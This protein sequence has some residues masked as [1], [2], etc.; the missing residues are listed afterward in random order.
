MKSNTSALSVL[1]LSGFILLF[2]SCISPKDTATSRSMQN[3][4][5]RYNIVYN[6]NILLDES[7]RNIENGYIDNYSQLLPLYKEPSEASAASEITNLDSLIRKADNI[8]N[9]KVNS[10]YLDEAY[11]LI[12]KS[13]YLQA[14]FF[15]AAEYFSYIY[16]TYPLEKEHRQEALVW[17]ARALMQ[18]ENIAEASNTL[19]TALKYIENSKNHIPDVY[20][21][22]AQLLISTNK[23]AE[24][25]TILQKAIGAN[26]SKQSKLR[27]TYILAQLQEE[28][29]QY[30]E[31]YS[32]FS[33]VVKSNASFEMAFNANLNRIRIEEEQSGK[34]VDR[35]TR[36]QSL[37]KDDKNKDF[38]DQIYFQIGNIYA[39]RN[40]MPEAIASYTTS[41][42]KTTFNQNQK[43]L[44]YLSIADM[45]FD[46][47]D[48]LNAKAYYDSTLTTLSPKYPGYEII[49]KKGNNLELLADRYRTISREDT[50]QLL[51]RLPE[52]QRD[53]RIGELVRQQ[54]QNVIDQSNQQSSV[55]NLIAG[56]DNPTSAASSEGKFYF[57]NTTALSQGLIDFKRKWGTRKLEDNWRRAAKSAEESTQ[58]LSLDPDSPP[59]ASIPT[60]GDVLSPETIRQNYIKD[61]PLTEPLVTQSNQK[62]AVAYYDIANFYKDELK[63]DEL[64][65]KTFEELLQ[66]TPTSTYSLP[67]YYNL[68]RLYQPSD[69]KKSTFYKNKILTDFPESP[70]A[71]VISD[72]NYSRKSDEKELA[73]N[74]SYN[75][76]FNLYS[77]RKYTEI[78]P[79]A[80]LIFQTY[81]NNNISPQ[82]A[83]LNAMAIGHT[84]K[85][86]VFEHALKAIVD[87]YPKDEFITPLVK[88]HLVYIQG[89]RVKMASRKTALT[90]FDPLEPAFTEEPLVN[91]SLVLSNTTPQ[92]S[93][94]PQAS[95]TPSTSQPA[96]VTPDPA[97][98]VSKPTPEL[99]T[100]ITNVA[101]KESKTA[102]TLF[103]LPGSGQY[104]FAINIIDPAITLSSTRFGIGQFNRTRYAGSS[105][106]HQLQEVNNENQIILVGVFA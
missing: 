95:A 25:I 24:A 9:E 45:Y 102:S 43:G 79:A 2:G 89:E 51:A 62:I 86:D 98:V 15:N 70:F 7:S 12:A 33:K 72:P 87:T 49:R 41:I 38:I 52:S 80:T 56:I 63:D 88:Q 97:S 68:Y 61:L 39:E 4:T 74:T 22:Y 53:A 27:W 14:K 81:P 20:A 59:P 64:A 100:A 83:Y 78:L 42:K 92:A 21:T 37:L 60:T 6:S 77:E 35:I 31:A 40:Q 91:K 17:K 103:S 54:S 71:K 16:K 26:P 55:N 58:M 96:Y 10:K 99:P 29:K 101:P 19:D 30:A 75:E 50:L 18:L 34:K 32:N 93:A 5:A 76:L 46:K 73:L 3:L 8:V 69:E 106:K 11:L 94:I 84:Q 36:L 90:D 85:L 23:E 104:Y 28:Q 1:I 47:A 65:I 67:V 13:N 105:L 66:H 57:N 44:S 82:I 48:Y